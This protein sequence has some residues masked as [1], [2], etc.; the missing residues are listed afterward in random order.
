M[1]APT[2][3]AGSGVAG[4]W[5]VLADLGVGWKARGMD[6][7][8]TACPGASWNGGGG[9]GCLEMQYPCGLWGRVF[10]CVDFAFG[11]G[12][13]LRCRS[14]LSVCLNRRMSRCR[15][16]AGGCPAASHFLLLRQKKVT[17]EKATRVR[18]L[19]LC[20]R[21]PALL[22]SAGGLR[23]LA[24]LKQRSPTAPASAALLGGSHGKGWGAT[25]SGFDRMGCH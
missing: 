23:K 5:R 3:A 25:V 10:V 20:A 16:C 19:A 1:H 6:V 13:V 4:R 11:L 2:I 18:R 22:A 24:S 12:G 21:C 9:A 14:A 8:G 7:A 17:K 15:R